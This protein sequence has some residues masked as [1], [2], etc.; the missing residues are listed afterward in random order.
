MYSSNDVIA[1]NVSISNG[2]ALQ[3][4]EFN[5]LELFF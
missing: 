2:V 4:A 3:F 5:Y 1:N